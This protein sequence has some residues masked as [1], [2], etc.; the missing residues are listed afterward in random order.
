MFRLCMGFVYG[1]NSKI[2]SSDLTEWLLPGT[3]ETVNR[4]SVFLKNFYFDIWFWGLPR[5]R[6]SFFES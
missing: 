2:S 3:K 5:I 6:W 1:K 4:L